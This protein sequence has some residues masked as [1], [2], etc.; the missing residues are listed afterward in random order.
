MI[1]DIITYTVIA[2]SLLLFIRSFI[3][4][5][6]VRTSSEASNHACGSCDKSCAL[7]S[8]MNNI[9]KNAVST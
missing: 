6:T 8:V 5:F 1:Q 4:F 3:R 7:K 2:A 9:E